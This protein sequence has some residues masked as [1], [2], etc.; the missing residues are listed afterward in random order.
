MGLTSACVVNMIDKYNERR[1]KNLQ[2]ADS[3]MYSKIE[4]V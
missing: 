1:L 2:R 4:E 3:V